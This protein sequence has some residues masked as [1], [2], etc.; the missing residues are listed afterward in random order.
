MKL[1]NGT[2]VSARK[3]IRAKCAECMAFD[4]DGRHD[5]NIPLCPL[6]DFQPYRQKE[7][8]LWWVGRKVKELYHAYNKARNNQ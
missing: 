8:I 7:P 6:Y 4:V 3:A 5:C 2:K 1:S